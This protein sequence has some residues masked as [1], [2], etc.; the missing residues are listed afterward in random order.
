MPDWLAISA[1][2]IVGYCAGRLACAAERRILWL[3]IAHINEEIARLE[4]E[5]VARW[6]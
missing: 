6:N 2:L 4:T 3:I 1:A 5:G